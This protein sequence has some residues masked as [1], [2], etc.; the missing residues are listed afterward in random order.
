MYTD[1]NYMMFFRIGWDRIY[2]VQGES[3]TK[4]SL[5]GKSATNT[6]PQPHVHI[7]HPMVCN[8]YLF[9]ICYADRCT[10]MSVCYVH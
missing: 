10:L 2:E 5:S 8:L 9:F 1:I 7:N 6:L 4:A 3:G